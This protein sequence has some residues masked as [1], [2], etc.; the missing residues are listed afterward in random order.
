MGEDGM[1]GMDC[2]YLHSHGS[3]W[4]AGYGGMNGKK[5]MQQFVFERRRCRWQVMVAKMDSIRDA[6]CIGVFVE[7]AVTPVVV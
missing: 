5:S 1:E 3:R 2:C 4:C 7:D 6:D